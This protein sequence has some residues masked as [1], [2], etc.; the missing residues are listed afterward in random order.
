MDLE[1]KYPFLLP[2][3]PF[4]SIPLYSEPFHFAPN[5]QTSAH[6]RYIGG[7]KK[8]K[9]AHLMK[10]TKIREIRNS[11]HHLVGKYNPERRTI[12]IKRKGDV[13]IIRILPDGEIGVINVD[14]A[15]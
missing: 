6:L 7:K 1:P 9:E 10:E 4:P 8:A 3:L 5:P 15:A 14:S 11:K 13:T 12:Q 2:I